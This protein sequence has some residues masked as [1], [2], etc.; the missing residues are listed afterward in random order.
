MQL[1][2]TFTIGRDI[3]RDG[4]YITPEQKINID[5][6]I[7]QYVADNFGGATFIDGDGV[8]A[9]E[10][11]S[12]VSEKVTYVI[13]DAFAD[14]DLLKMHAENLAAIAHQQAVHMSAIAVYAVDVSHKGVVTE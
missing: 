12:V 5:R 6:R 10:G 2:T 13:V 11:T 3:N 1:R 8:W 9:P 7:R 4:M 14:L